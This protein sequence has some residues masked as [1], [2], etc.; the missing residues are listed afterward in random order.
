MANLLVDY[1]SDVH[2]ILAASVDAARWTT[3]MFDHALRLALGELN[4]QLVYETSFT[5]TVAGNEQD[6]ST[7]TAVFQVLTVAYPWVTGAEFGDCIVPFRFTGINK[8]YFA[9]AQ[10]AVGE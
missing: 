5:V 9:N 2:N 6:L 7:I 10:P 1:R 4:P 8:V 3:A